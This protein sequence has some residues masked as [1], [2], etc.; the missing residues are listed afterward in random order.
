MGV[1]RD[2]QAPIYDQRVTE[3]IAAQIKKK[4]EGDFDALF[5]SGDTWAV[6]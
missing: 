1:F 4:G 2:V 3:Q 5:N 6:E